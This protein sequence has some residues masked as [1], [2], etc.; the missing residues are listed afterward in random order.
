MSNAATVQKLLKC[1]NATA[2]AI[3]AVMYEY[4]QPSWSNDTA[5]SLR[6]DLRVVAELA[7]IKIVPMVK[8]RTA[9]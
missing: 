3:T 1:D 4:I 8:E 5:A 2:N 7:G 9:A 6:A